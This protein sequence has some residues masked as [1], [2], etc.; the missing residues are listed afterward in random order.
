MKTHIFRSLPLKADSRTTRN[1][2]IF[3]NGKSQTYTWEK[4]GGKTDSTIS[5]PYSKSGGKLQKGI[6]FF[7]FSIWV[8]IQVLKH[9]KK[10]DKV[11]FMDLETAALGL[12]AA[13]IKRTESI[14]DI[15]DPFAQTKIK[16]KTIQKL[17]DKIEIYIARHFDKVIIPH[18]SRIK[19]YSD[20]GISTNRIPKMHII[21]NVPLLQDGNHPKKPNR[22]I[23]TIGYFGTL[24]NESR[25]IEWL[26]EFC[27]RMNGKYNL[28]IAGGGAMQ[29][30]IQE[31]SHSNTNIEFLGPYS[32][33]QIP[34]LYSKIDF[35][36]AYYTPKIE[37][38]KYAAPNKFYEHIFFK[39]PIITSSCIPQ[40]K[41]IESLG[42]GIKVNAE[43]FSASEMEKLDRLIS[44][45][46]SKK[47]EIH[48]RLEIHWK[49]NYEI[50]Y[51]TIKRSE[52]CA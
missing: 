51:E 18:Q 37:L 48:N 45:I 43:D 15:V 38:H 2:Q 46:Q 23:I 28:L 47:N 32:A 21:E 5:F 24:D 39:T 17:L 19:Y 9:A 20:R 1:Q 26:I 8:P 40:N 12:L 22:E 34:E 13:K 29:N 16:S 52:V 44:E 3:S 50:Y 10:S 7:L 25:G 4:S 14:F 30:K 31:L 35:T 11:V 41:E 49:E 27:K 36:W 6:K 33:L 42:S